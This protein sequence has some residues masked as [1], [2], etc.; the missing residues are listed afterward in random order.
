MLTTLHYMGLSE[1]EHTTMIARFTAILHICFAVYF[2]FRLLTVHPFLPKLRPQQLRIPRLHLCILFLLALLPLILT[3]AHLTCVSFA[4]SW[5]FASLVAL[6]SAFDAPLFEYGTLRPRFLYYPRILLWR[7]DVMSYVFFILG[8]TAISTPFTLFSFVTS[9]VLAGAVVFVT[10]F[11]AILRLHAQ[12]IPVTVGNVLTVLIAPG[13]TPNVPFVAP[14]SVYDAPA[15][16]LLSFQWVAPL[17]VT[18]RNRS[19]EASDVIPMADPYLSHV[20]TN[21]RFLP[22]WHKQLLRAPGSR[23]SITIALF[24]AYGIRLALSGLLKVLNDVCVFTSPM[25]LR[26]VS[27]FFIISFNCHVLFPHVK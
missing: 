8:C 2:W 23:P 21:Y 13:T 10:L 11:D 26:S 17:I 18:G 7:L 1:S 5:V 24:Q 25:L 20:A 3:G 14:P 9:T 4:A 22:F 12:L 19:L 16:A 15:Y 6:R 27:V